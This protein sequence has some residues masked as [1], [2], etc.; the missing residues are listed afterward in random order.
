MLAAEA[1]EIAARFDDAD[2]AA[3]STLGHGQALL[4]MGDEAAGL[5]RLDEVMLAV[6]AGEVGPIA[7]GIVYCAVILEC[8]QLYDL[9]RAAEWTAA[10]DAWCGTQPDLVPY[11]GQCLVHQSQLQQAA[12]DWP[13]RGGDGRGGVRAAERAAASGARPGLLPGG[14]AAPA[15]RRNRRRRRR[16]PRV[17]ARPGTSRCRAWRCSSWRGATPVGRGGEHPPGPGRRRS[18]VPAPRAARR[19]VEIYVAAGDAGDGDAGGRRAGLDRPAVGSRWLAPWPTHARARCC[20]LPDRPP[21]RWRTSGRERRDGG[22]STCP[23]RRRAR[24]CCSGGCLALGDGAAAALE[25]DNA[26]A[27]FAALGAETDLAGLRTSPAR[28]AAA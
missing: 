3:F 11:R 28:R 1:G 17:P 25:F 9:A 7:S 24:R 14:R 8:M 13:R 19:G 15:A 18:A 10:L 27:T 16:V 20:W 5:A 12:G 22:G 26:R 23:T 4:A 21:R 2:L 6:S